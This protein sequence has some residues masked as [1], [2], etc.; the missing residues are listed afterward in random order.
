MT[1]GL[2]TA[3]R[4]AGLD[5]SITT[6]IGTSGFVDV[7][8]GTRPATGGTATNKLAHLPLSATAA[9]ASSGGVLTFNAITAAAALLSGTATWCRFTTSAGTAVA[10]ASVG[11]S[12][13]DL[14]LNST[15]ISSGATVSVTSATLTA[16]NP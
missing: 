12:G 11:T 2:S 8:D 13:A 5:A 3:S 1:V 10:D 14:N 16:G 7:Y 6:Q 4:N 9:A 15:A